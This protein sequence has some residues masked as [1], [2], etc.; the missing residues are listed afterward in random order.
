MKVMPVILLQT[1][2]YITRCSEQLDHLKFFFSY[3][4]YKLARKL[5]PRDSQ[6]DDEA[7]LDCRRF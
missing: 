6:L 7:D 4:E 3:F 2:Y 1:N 5:P